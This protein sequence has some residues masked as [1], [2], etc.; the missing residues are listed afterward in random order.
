[1]IVKTHRTAISAGKCQTKIFEMR[2]SKQSFPSR[3]EKP[4]I[5][6][7]GP[8]S[9]DNSLIMPDDQRTI[10]ITKGRPHQVATPPP[11]SYLD[12]RI[13]E[14]RKPAPPA[15]WGKVV[16]PFAVGLCLGLLAPEAIKVA[17]AL[18]YWGEKLSFPFTL[19][20]ARPEFDYGPSESKVLSTL[21][22]YLQFPVEGA[23]AMLNLRRHFPLRQTMSRL[24][25]L[26]IA[27]AGML[28]MFDH[29]NLR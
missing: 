21:A 8:Q 26:P 28:W 2:P 14:R 9:T 6:R 7:V 18:G 20:A 23:L 22:L 29:P 12:R 25:I 5:N 17:G 10:S 24:A 11:P 3:S 4:G 19:L 13:G 16:W 27:G 1:M 15:P